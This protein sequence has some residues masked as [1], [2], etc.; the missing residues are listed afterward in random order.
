LKVQSARNGSGLFYNN[1]IESLHSAIKAKTNGKQS[2]INLI[3]TIESIIARQRQEEVRAIHQN[4]DIRLA[5]E[6][7]SF[8]VG[9]SY[10]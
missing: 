7:Q 4:G 6:Y 3:T 10:T 2:I 5:K 9:F 8:K 1:A